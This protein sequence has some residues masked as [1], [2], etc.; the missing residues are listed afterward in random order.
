M[1]SN[2]R[3]GIEPEHSTLGAWSLSPGPPE[4]S[5]F[6]CTFKVG[7]LVT[8]SLKFSFIWACLDYSSLLNGIFT[9]YRF[10]GDSALSALE[11]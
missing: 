9:G 2:S 4:K 6:K 1:G 7:L 3:P 10:L 5:P 11:M 8:N